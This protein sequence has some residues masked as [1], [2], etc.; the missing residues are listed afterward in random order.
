MEER[1][2]DWGRRGDGV[3]RGVRERWG[4]GGLVQDIA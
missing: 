3:C 2:R 1:K 4:G